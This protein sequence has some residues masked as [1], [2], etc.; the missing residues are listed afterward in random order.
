MNEVNNH[1][2]SIIMK[3]AYIIGEMLDV[4]GK[5][6]GYNLSFAF[7]SALATAKD[8]LKKID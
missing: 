2:N 1:C 8:I 4:D 7:L 3:N 5:C 6:G